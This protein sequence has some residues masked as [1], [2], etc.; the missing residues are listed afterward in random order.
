MFH[1][2]FSVPGQISVSRLPESDYVLVDNKQ[3]KMVCTPNQWIAIR[4]S[5]RRLH[6]LS[7][8][9]TPLSSTDRLIV[10]KE[11]KFLIPVEALE[12]FRGAA[13]I[14]GHGLYCLVIDRSVHL[15]SVLPQLMDLMPFTADRPKNSKENGGGSARYD[16]EDGMGRWGL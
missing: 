11:K 4:A 12:I 8:L 9:S 3:C 16:R 13:K 7:T 15:R 5:L 10:V 14:G 6:A 2:Q 1:F